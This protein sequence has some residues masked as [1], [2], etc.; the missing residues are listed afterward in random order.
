MQERVEAELEL[1]REQFPDVEYRDEGRWVFI[2]SYDLPQGW[3]RDVTPVAFQINNGHP[4]DLPYGI[5]VPAGILFDGNVPE[6]YRELAKNSPP[7]GGS[8]GLFSWTPEEGTW[9]P[10]ADV[11]SGAN[12]LDWVKSFRRRFAEGA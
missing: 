5:Y 1:I 12:L 6:N 7:F 8:W 3:N 2:P 10:T 4:T 9:K 11:R